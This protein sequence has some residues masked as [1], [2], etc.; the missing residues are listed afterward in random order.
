VDGTQIF[1]Y[2][3]E[4]A[5]PSLAEAPIVQRAHE[6]NA[7][8]R[9]EYSYSSIT[10]AYDEIFGSDSNAPYTVEQIRRFRKNPQRYY[11]ELRKMA[12][13]CYAANG[14]VTTAI[15][16]LKSLF[17]LDSVVWCKSKGRRDK[18]PS[19]YAKNKSLMLSTLNTIKYKEFIRDALFKAANEGM[20]IG[21]FEVKYPTS[22]V[23]TSLTDYDVGNITE[24]NELGFNATVM[25]LPIEYTKLVGRRNNNYVCAFDL[26]Y[27]RGMPQDERDRNLLA[28]PAEIRESYGKYK[29]GKLKGSWIV[30]DSDKT[31][32]VKI[33]SDIADPFGIPFVIAAMDDILY[34]QYFL[35]SKRLLLDI[36]NNQ[37]IYE[38]YPEGQ[39]KG[40]SSLTGT[41]QKAQHNIIRDALFEKHNKFGI[42]FFSLAANTKLDKIKIDTDLLDEKNE[43]GIKNNINKGIGVS[44]TAL[45]GSSSGNFAATTVNL[46]V[47][48]AHVYTWV[49]QITAELNKAINANVIRDQSCR[50]EFYILPTT[51]VNRD[52][53][54]KY[55][56]ELYTT[57]SGSLIGWVASTGFNY[58]VYLSLMDY[59]LEEDFYNKYPVH[60]TSFNSAG[61]D[62]SGGDVGGRPPIPDSTVATTITTTENRSNA[63]PKPSTG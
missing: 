54:V 58:E 30:L 55:M 15:D 27:F 40:T 57:G 18:Y 52:K 25:A 13:W 38:V 14:T 56:R 48:A 44:A 20:Y 11:Y 1:G 16:L 51:F 39:T 45:D 35:D 31:L 28:F 37:I 62:S 59:E 8:I 22:N 53:M 33:K 61:G 17:T 50:V 2:N 49:E 12:M 6:E 4:K 29:D 21:Y 34:L 23:P 24:I 10:S 42:S 7:S 32:V 26:G 43:N 46:E 36:A 5:A 41:Q 3:I 19:S 47:I 9:S 63:A 60:K